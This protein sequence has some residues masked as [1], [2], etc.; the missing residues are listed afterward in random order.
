MGPGPVAETF[1][2]PLTELEVDLWAE[3]LREGI[4]R[5]LRLSGAAAEHDVEAS[6]VLGTFGGVPRWTWS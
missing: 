6:P 3:P 4:L 2:A 1:P 5:A